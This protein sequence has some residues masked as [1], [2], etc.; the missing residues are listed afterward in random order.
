MKKGTNRNFRLE[1]VNHTLSKPIVLKDGLAIL[2]DMRYVFYPQQRGK[3]MFQDRKYI[4]AGR[5]RID[6]PFVD[7]QE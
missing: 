3:L 2:S 4:Q 7:F 1:Q 6:L 5:S